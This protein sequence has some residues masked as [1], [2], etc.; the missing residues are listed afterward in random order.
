M[1]QM[2]LVIAEENFNKPLSI[3]LGGCD[4]LKTAANA[5]SAFRSR[6]SFRESTNQFDNRRLPDL[7][8][9]QVGVY[10]VDRG[11]VAWSPIRAFRRLDSEKIEP[12]RLRFPLLLVPLLITFHLA[13]E[14]AAKTRIGLIKGSRFNRYLWAFN[15]RAVIE[16]LRRGV[17]HFAR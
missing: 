14:N 12:T 7:H 15:C 6:P 17:I 13:R 16:F 5:C 1:E 2:F 10:Q 11:N 9:L 3:N 8:E 4:F